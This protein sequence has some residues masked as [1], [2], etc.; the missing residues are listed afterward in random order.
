MYEQRLYGISVT[1]AEVLFAVAKGLESWL[2]E[3]LTDHLNLASG[4]PSPISEI[5]ILDPLLF[6]CLQMV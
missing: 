4:L 6:S 3:Q 5:I 1:S 2:I